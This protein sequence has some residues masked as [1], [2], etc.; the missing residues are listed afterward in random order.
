MRLFTSG[1]DKAFLIQL[2]VIMAVLAAVFYWQAES[3]T[4]DMISK[5]MND[6]YENLT[7]NLNDWRIDFVILGTSHSNAVALPADIHFFNLSE[8]Q[9]IPTVMYFRAKTLVRHHPEVRTVYLEADDHLFFNGEHYSLDGMD[10]VQKRNSKVFEWNSEYIDNDEEKEAVFGEVAPYVQE[11]FLLLRDDIRPVIIKRLVN[12]VWPDPAQG[13]LAKTQAVS[14]TVSDNC[15]LSHFP[16]DMDLDTP[17]AW[18]ARAEADRQLRMQIRLE[19]HNLH[20]SGPM[21]DSML[22]YYDKTIALLKAHHIDVVLVRYP[23]VETFARMKNSAG[24]KRYL[25]FIQQMADKH[26]IRILD[27][28]PLSQHGERFFEDQDHVSHTLGWVLGKSIVQDFCASQA[29][30]AAPGNTQ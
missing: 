12:R 15:D 10:P 6:K 23:V 13:G 24:Q 9:N 4:R 29:G 21:K 3:L 22:V 20:L 27:L 11:R 30:R 25:D 28:T 17:S 19:E 16:A 8:A 18:T 1:S 2:P 7:Q 5:K 26:G 14:A